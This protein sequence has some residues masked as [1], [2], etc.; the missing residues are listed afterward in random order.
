M[1][2]RGSV[3]NCRCG[4]DCPA[5]RALG[6]CVARKLPAV[7]VE[8]L[9]RKT[10][11][12]RRFIVVAAMAL[13]IV[14]ELLPIRT[15]RQ[16]GVLRRKRHKR[17]RDR[18]RRPVRI[19]RPIRRAAWALHCLWLG[20]AVIV[21]VHRGAPSGGVVAAMVYAIIRLPDTPIRVGRAPSLA[22]DWV[23]GQN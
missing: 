10:R 7:M 2:S 13:G 23:R 9:S 16:P 17:A 18:G 14:R 8:S 19:L 4:A 12:V 6:A 3:G 15:W 1:R 22:F 20:V 21:S 11:R 5:A